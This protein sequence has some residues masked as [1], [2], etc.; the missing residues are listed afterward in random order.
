[1]VI[2]S[3]VTVLHFLAI[4]HFPARHEVLVEGTQTVGRLHSAV[5]DRQPDRGA[6]QL[7][8]RLLLPLHPLLAD[9]SWRTAGFQGSHNHRRPHRQRSVSEWHCHRTGILATAERGVPVPGLVGHLPH[10]GLRSH[11]PGRQRVAGQ[12]APAQHAADGLRGQDQLLA[13]SVALAVAG[14]QPPALP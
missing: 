9:G 4:H 10:S 5:A 8:V 11:H 12:Q 1:M 7:A 3:L 13:V 14:L 2:G 6:H